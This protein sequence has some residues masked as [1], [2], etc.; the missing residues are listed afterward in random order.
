MH[1][2]IRIHNFTCGCGEMR[3]TLTLR[4]RITGQVFLKYKLFGRSVILFRACI[5][6]CT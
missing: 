4:I 1:L 3:I 2:S 6:S 5:E